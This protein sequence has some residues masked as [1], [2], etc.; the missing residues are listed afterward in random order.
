MI[1]RPQEPLFSLYI[2]QLRARKKPRF[3]FFSLATSSKDP[4][5]I[6]INRDPKKRD[7]PQAS[8]TTEPLTFVHSLDAGLCFGPL[9]LAPA[10]ERFHGVFHIADWY[11]TLSS[12]AGVDYED[13]ASADAHSFR[14]FSLILFLQ[15]LG[16]YRY[17]PRVWSNHS[18]ERGLNGVRFE[19]AHIGA[20]S[21]S[22]WTGYQP[23]NQIMVGLNGS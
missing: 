10:P 2:Q 21:S 8:P 16:S 4:S 22:H 13:H 20:G 14:E 6:L 5:R 12:L 1:F 9:P 3:G 23:S 18:V 7:E 17:S 11:A 15:A 19:C